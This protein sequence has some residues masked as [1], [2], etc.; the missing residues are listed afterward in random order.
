MVGLFVFV[1]IGD[2]GVFELFEFGLFFCQVSLDLLLD[3]CQ[4]YHA[5]VLCVVF[6]RVYLVAGLY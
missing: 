3:S 6:Q 5:V 1:G 2:V 4:S